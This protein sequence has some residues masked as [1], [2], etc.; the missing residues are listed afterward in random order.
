MVSLAN[1]RLKK[2]KMCTVDRLNPTN[3][4]LSKASCIPM[5]V[6]KQ[7]L[8]HFIHVPNHFYGFR[9]NCC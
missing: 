2:K 8:F 3:F 4:R 1:G 7:L 5:I 6:N 9:R